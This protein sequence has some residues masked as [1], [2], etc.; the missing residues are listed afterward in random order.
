MVSALHGAS[1]CGWAACSPPAA[2][3]HSAAELH[4]VGLNEPGPAT[5]Y[6]AAATRLVANASLSSQLHARTV[7]AGN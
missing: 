1:R 7:Q 5:G 2:S 6:V 3:S 4:T